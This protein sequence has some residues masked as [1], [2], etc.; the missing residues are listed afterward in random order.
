M[1][2]LRPIVL[3]FSVFSRIPVPEVAW[4]EENMRYMICALPLVEPPSGSAYG[5]GPG[6]GG[7]LALVSFCKLPGLLYCR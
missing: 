7:C 5:S 1:K 3:A 6:W 4:D 2:L